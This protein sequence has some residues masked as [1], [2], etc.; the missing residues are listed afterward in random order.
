MADPISPG[1]PA[2]DPAPDIAPRDH[3][4]AVTRAAG[5]SFYL[6]MRILPEARR[7]AMFAIYAF[8]RSPSMNRRTLRSMRWRRVVGS[9]GRRTR[10]VPPRSSA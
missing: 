10:A 4:R 9:A 1:S 5:S 8:C 3:V 2:A 6:G 7:D